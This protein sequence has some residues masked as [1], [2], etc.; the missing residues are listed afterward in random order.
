MVPE[1]LH[2]YSHCL[3]QSNRKACKFNVGIF[4]NGK[5]H[6][7][8]QS[9][10]DYMLTWMFGFFFSFSIHIYGWHPCC[11]GGGAGNSCKCLE[12]KWT[13][14]LNQLYNHLHVFI[15][16]LLVHVRTLRTPPALPCLAPLGL[17]PPYPQPRTPFQ[18]PQGCPSLP[19]QC[20]SEVLVSSS[21]QPYPAWTWALPSWA[22]VT[23]QP[24]PV[25]VLMACLAILGLCLAPV[26]LARPNPCPQT[27][28]L[29]WP[30]P[31]P[32][33][34]PMDMPDVLGWG[35][36]QPALSPWG[37]PRGYQCPGSLGRCWS[38]RCPNSS[39]GRKWKGAWCSCVWFLI[40]SWFS[41][42]S[43]AFP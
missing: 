7:Q 20:C 29:A 32:I 8:W 10:I 41:E 3:E 25:P 9:A 28:I 36:P 6:M 19:Q 26:T 21:P 14:G 34:I 13:S 30:Q 33:P 4:R 23:D 15:A 37:S 5:C 43:S 35:C 39:N 11:T 31:M 17:S 16:L 22:D 12:A 42:N 38:P 2:C 1:H 40:S 18:S 24:W 27:D